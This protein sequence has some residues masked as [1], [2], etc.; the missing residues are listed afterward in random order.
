[1]PKFG[2]QGKG[3]DRKQ[4]KKRLVQRFLKPF[5]SRGNVVTKKGG[6]TSRH[7][8][9][10][11]K[12]VDSENGTEL[13]ERKSLLD[14]EGILAGTAET[15]FSDSENQTIPH[16]VK[17]R[18]TPEESVKNRVMFN[19]DYDS[20]F[21]D[22]ASSFVDQEELERI[23]IS[24]SDIGPDF[25]RSRDE[26]LKIPIDQ[27]DVGIRMKRPS[28]SL[29]MPD[30]K[31]LDRDDSESSKN[32][33]PEEETELKNETFESRKDR[34]L[35]SRSSTYSSPMGKK[36]L[37]PKVEF[38]EALGG[39]GMIEGRSLDTLILKKVGKAI[40]STDESIILYLLS[41]NA[42]I[43]ARDMYGATPLH[44]AVQR[45]NPLA[46]NE[47]LTKADIDIEVSKVSFTSWKF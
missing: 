40:R 31:S 38:D 34:K 17:E 32:F 20:Y 37:Q 16:I 43:N 24:R 14:F 33:Y 44:Y 28:K 8:A 35:I 18:A 4:D 12:V 23:S 26:T 7:E 5:A 45:S 27:T 3:K 9:G 15:V 19:N 30:I 39:D 41:K 47:L 25:V 1:M 10:E 42:N 13:S 21:D 46:V 2:R 36:L 29:S 11:E 6:E 22:E